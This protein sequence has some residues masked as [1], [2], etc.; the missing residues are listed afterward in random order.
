MARPRNA[1]LLH[2]ELKGAC[3]DV[4][5]Q[6]LLARTLLRLFLRTW[7]PLYRSDGRHASRPFRHVVPV[8]DRIAFIFH[9][10]SAGF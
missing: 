5:P 9:F 6:H 2:T 3:D 4:L 10:R 8:W 1:I 7:P